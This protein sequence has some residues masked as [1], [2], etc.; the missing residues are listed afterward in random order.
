MQKKLI[1]LAVASLVS[2]PVFAQS[3]VQVYG[4]IDQALTSGN[5]GAGSVTDLRSGGY[6]TERLGFQGSEDLGNGMK[7]NFRLETG[8][9]SDTGY[10]DQGNTGWLFQRESRV[11]LSGSWGHVNFGRQYT[12]LFSVQGANDIFRVVGVGSYYSLMNTGMTRASNAI[13]YDSN[14]INGLSFG[15]MYS[16]GD[17]AAVTASGGSSHQES[18]LAPK[19][20]GRHVGLNVRYANGPLSLDLG[21]GNQK[22]SALAAGL[23]SPIATKATMVA[24]MYDFKVVKINAGWQTVNDDANPKATDLRMWD[25]GATVPVM[26]H[27]Q[28]KFNYTALQNKLPGAT[29][30]DSKLI[31][32]GYVHPMS[33]RTVLYGTW[34]K[35]TNETGVARTLLGSPGVTNATGGANLGYDPSAVQI[36]IQHAF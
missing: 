16:M 26:G 28:V 14:S 13:R 7:A 36:G 6:T 29:N 15:A 31:A 20:L 18:T 35:M 32:L 3:Q 9:N 2:A 8:M 4:V 12:P 33:K 22:A 30:V 17:T 23:T 24:G 25:I 10:H 21:Y 34:A 27:D 1:A 11:G 5:Y 19:D